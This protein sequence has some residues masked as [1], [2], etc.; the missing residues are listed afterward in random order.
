[1]TTKNFAVYCIMVCVLATLVFGSTQFTLPKCCR[2]RRCD[3]PK[4]YTCLFGAGSQ[5]V[6]CIQPREKLSHIDEFWGN[7]CPKTTKL[8]CR[9]IDT[10][11]VCGCGSMLAPVHSSLRIDIGPRT[12]LP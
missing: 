7:F 8:L 9:K 2:K 12:N 6:A 5:K 3:A 10:D 1:M 11:Y 4:I